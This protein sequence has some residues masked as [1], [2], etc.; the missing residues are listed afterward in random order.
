MAHLKF[1]GITMNFCKS[2]ENE[3]KIISFIFIVALCIRLF[4]LYYLKSY[5][6]ADNWDFGYETGSVASAIAGGEGFSS[7]F[8][9]PTGPTALLPPL[10]P[11]LLACIFKIFGI[12]SRESAVVALSVNCL[13]SALTCIPLYFIGKKLFGREAGYITTAILAV[14]PV[15]VWYAVNTVWDTAIFTFLCMSLIYGAF[16][17]PGRFTY[18][19][20]AL[21]GILMGITALL[22][23]VIIAFYPFLLIWLY[24]RISNPNTIRSAEQDRGAEAIFQKPFQKPSFLKKLGFSEKIHIFIKP[25]TPELFRISVLCLAAFGVLFPWLLRNYVMF[26]RPMINSNFGLEFKLENNMNTWKAFEKTGDSSVFMK[27]HPTMNPEEFYLYKVVREVI[28]MK[29]CLDDART[30]IREHPGKFIYLTLRRI[31]YFWC[32]N[33]GGNNDW[34]G[35]LKVSFSVS[36]LKKLFSFLPLPL[37][38]L[39]IWAAIRRRRH[40]TEGDLWLI[41][42]YLFSLPLV[43]YL[44]H[45]C[46]RFRYPLE[47]MMLLF[48]V[49]GLWDMAGRGER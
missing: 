10:Y 25:R 38:L 47:P 49:Y 34:T 30:F 28:Y 3:N 27:A 21:Y 33:L 15:S 46:A 12:F 36:G 22:K 41:A 43:Y 8:R 42:A 7:P 37:M 26:G 40:E 11:Y 19:N 14:Y 17:L 24:I 2:C 6:I 5:I 18:R 35:N 4:C 44:T 29:L 1:K 45:V 20:A 39:G 31:Y 9:E 48:A 23:S 32:G 13:F 16:L